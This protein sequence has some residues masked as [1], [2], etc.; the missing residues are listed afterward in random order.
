MNPTEAILN[1]PTEPLAERT[2]YRLDVGRLRSWPP[3]TW[4]RHAEYLVEQADRIRDYIDRQGGAS[5]E[6]LVWGLKVP[7]PGLED[8][9]A[10][11]DKRAEWERLQQIE[12]D[13][14]VVYISARDRLAHTEVAPILRTHP[15]IAANDVWRL[16]NAPDLSSTEAVA[17]AVADVDIPLRTIPTRHGKKTTRQYAAAVVRLVE[18]LRDI[19]AAEDRGPSSVELYWRLPLSFSFNPEEFGEDV[20][21]PL[22]SLEWV[23]APT[24]DPWLPG[25]DA[26]FALTPAEHV[27][28]TCGRAFDTAQALGSHRQTHGDSADAEAD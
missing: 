2:D 10:E 1:D 27:C 19:E 12:E 13:R 26:E 21:A 5:D 4:D 11:A 22:A 16:E 23:D 9:Y 24:A 15:R 3:S 8:I 25:A 20:L 17:D 6:A 14:R 28:E 18:T 7:P